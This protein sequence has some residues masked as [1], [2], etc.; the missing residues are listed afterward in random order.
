M[1]YIPKGK[2]KFYWK[3][4]IHLCCNCASYT[5]VCARDIHCN[6]LYIYDSLNWSGLVRTFL[7]IQ[8]TLWNMHILRFKPSIKC[9]YRKFWKKCLLKFFIFLSV[10]YKHWRRLSPLLYVY[11]LHFCWLNKV[12]KRTIFVLNFKFCWFINSALQAYYQ[13]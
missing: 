3:S 2:R 6:V 4:I 5:Y 12:A 7:L 10:L 13:Q 9:L 8:N 11:I 1:I